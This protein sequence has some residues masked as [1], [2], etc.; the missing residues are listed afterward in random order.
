MGDNVGSDWFGRDICAIACDCVMGCNLG[1]H[2]WAAIYSLEVPL[3]VC[4]LPTICTVGD[5]AFG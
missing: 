1:V 5:W 2:L 4:L 3:K